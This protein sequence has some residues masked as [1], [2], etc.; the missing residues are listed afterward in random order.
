MFPVAV[1]VIAA[2]AATIGAGL[3]AP[4]LLGRHLAPIELIAVAG[5]F[6]LC[7]WAVMA[8]QRRRQRKRTQGMRDSALW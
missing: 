1:T 5:V 6:A 2:L 7:G 8:S 4:S 3:S